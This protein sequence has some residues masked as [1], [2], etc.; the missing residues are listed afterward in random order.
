[1]FNFDAAKNTDFIIIMITW[2]AATAKAITLNHTPIHTLHCKK[3]IP[4]LSAN[5]NSAVSYSKIGPVKPSFKSWE[6]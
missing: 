2:K 5:P 4:K 3:S 6:V 1:M